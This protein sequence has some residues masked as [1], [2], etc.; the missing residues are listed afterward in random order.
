MKT[1]YGTAA[2][3]SMNKKDSLDKFLLFLYAVRMK[4]WLKYLIGVA[5]GVA[6]VFAVPRNSS[7]IRYFLEFCSLYAVKIGKYMVIPLVFTGGASAVIAL[8]DSKQLL[9][10][11]CAVIA[12]IAASSVLLTA[13]GIVS[14]SLVRLPRIPITVEKIT[15]SPVLNIE[16]VAEAL[17]PNSALETFLNNSFLLPVFL[18]ACFIGIACVSDKSKSKP[19]VLLIDSLSNISYCIQSFIMDI[20]PVGMIAI[21]FSWTIEYF[22]VISSGAFRPLIL[23]LTADFLLITVVIYP[24]IF[25]FVCKGHNPFRLLYASIAPVIAA[26]LSG[27]ANYTLPFHIRHGTE[28]LGIRQRFS[29]FVFPLFS[30][31]ARGGSALVVSISFIVILRSYSPLAIRMEDIV[32]IA[33]VSFGLSFLLCI[34]PSGGAYIALITLCGIYGRGFE[35][36]YLLLKPAAAIICAYAAVIDTVTAMFGAYIVA[37]KL[38]MIEDKELV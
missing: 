34:H 13:I 9:K 38:K 18:L 6:L 20:M 25:Y 12:A 26:F 4:I 28:S 1:F 31:L 23:L 16:T 5:L 36:V 22:G 27:D 11:F 29:G 14:V 8:R 32:T 37:F 15:E 2:F 10:S 33:A 3:W 24:L 17:F 19:V 21:A 30:V 7:A 35:V